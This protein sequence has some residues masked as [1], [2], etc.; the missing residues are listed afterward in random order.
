MEKTA[1]FFDRVLYARFIAPHAVDAA[2]TMQE[3]LLLWPMRTGSE[4]N[5]RSS[6][7]QL[8]A[9]RRAG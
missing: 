5:Y 8:F 3:S 1:F 6:R 9:Y 4:L 7:R 2:K